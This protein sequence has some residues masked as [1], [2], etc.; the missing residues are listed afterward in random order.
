MIRSPRLCDISPRY[1]GTRVSSTYKCERSSHWRGFLPSYSRAE[2]SYRCDNLTTSQR[3]LRAISVAPD[4]SWQPAFSCTHWLMILVAL[5]VSFSVSVANAHSLCA[6]AN[7]SGER[8]TQASADQNV[9]LIQPWIRQQ[10]A[11]EA[12]VF[13]ALQSHGQCRKKM[14][15]YYNLLSVRTVSFRTEIQCTLF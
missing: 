8:F 1:C 10:L 7:A 4:I 14:F 6:N 9:C 15:S 11:L 3:Y 12:E 2:N 13:A 5:L